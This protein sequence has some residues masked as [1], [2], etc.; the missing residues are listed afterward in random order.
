MTKY[1]IGRLLQSVIVVLG[2]MIVVFFVLFHT[3]DPT[4]LFASQ[5][6]TVQQLAELRHSLG[7]DLPWYQQMFRYL[8]HSIHGDFG[9]SLQYHQSVA[10]VVFERLPATLELS[11]LA[12]ALALLVAIP[13]GV[14]AAVRRNSFWDQAG[15]GF[16]VLGQ[17]IPSF[18]LG[19]LL[20]WIFSGKLGWF[21]VTGRGSG[22]LD[23]LHHMLLP[24]IALGLL[25]M[26]R[27]A[28]LLRSNLLEVLGQ[29]YIRTAR[30]KGLK[31]RIVVFKHA[32]RNAVIPVV[33]V[34][35]LDFGVLLSGSV[36]TETV[37]AYPGVGLLLIKAIQQKDFPLVVGAVTVLAVIFV[38]LNLL[39]DLLYGYLDPRIHYA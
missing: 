5:N 37:F 30:A 27:N 12:Y 19:F 38:V 11:V 4:L 20:L 36:V 17:S 6:M 9:V 2:A 21:P 31:E 3:G 32:V 8:A 34:A 26:A 29:D 23:Q 24:A 14:I 15:M 7:F 28:R 18:F 35:G 33:T 25:S 39:V 22:L 1:I 16:A 13:I 10:R